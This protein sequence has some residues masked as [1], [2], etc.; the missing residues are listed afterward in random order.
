MME[1]PVQQIWNRL[2]NRFI[3]YLCWMLEKR[4][5]EERENKRFRI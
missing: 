5:Y 1:I 4:N 3:L 2:N